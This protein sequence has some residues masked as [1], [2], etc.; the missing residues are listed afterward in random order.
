M[1]IGKF[2]DLNNVSKDT[3]RHYMDL[4]LIV[5]EMRGGQYY[6]DDRCQKSFQEILSLKEMGFS[7]NEIKT[8][9]LFKLFGN[10][11]DYQQNHYYRALFTN[12]HEAVAREIE[13]LKAIE[14]KLGE[15]I[16][17]LSQNEYRKR[18]ALGI[19]IGIIHMFKCTKCGGN[20]MISEGKI[21]D[22]QILDGKLKCKC[23][24]EFVIE[25]GIVMVNNFSSDSNTFFDNNFIS[26]YI[27]ETD[28]NYL[29]NIYNAI[30]WVRRK[31]DF[32]DLKGKVIIDLGSGLGF[33]LRNIFSELPDDCL[34]IAVDH[35]IRRHRFLKSML[36]GAD[37]RKNIIFICAD[38]LQIPIGD[39]SVD[40]IFDFSGTSNYSFEHSEFLLDLIDHY[41]KDNAALIGSYI[42]FKNFGANSLIEDK[43]RKN[44]ILQN[45]KNW[46][47]GLKYRTINE[48]TSDYVEKSGIYENYFVKGER[49]Y[50][51]I[52]YG[53]R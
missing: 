6:F 10:L 34:Y 52:F 31:I 16:K 11:T 22:N 8:I 49:V 28:Y 37:V 9:F 17:E 29:H 7:L 25:D 38:F 45:V 48:K 5:P 33:G 4:G 26:S 1:R 21:N 51:Y 24:E 12:K 13:N 15:Q 47:N 14:S 46:I 50:S 44:F 23:G 36:E 53:K 41:V 19:D 30:E 35:D 20:L 39:K 3:I 42:L 18:F 43:Y 2:A 27:N 40:F 32:N